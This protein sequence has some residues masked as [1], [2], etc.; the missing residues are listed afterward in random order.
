MK[1]QKREPNHFSWH[2]FNHALTTLEKQAGTAYKQLKHSLPKMNAK[3]VFN[4]ALKKKNQVAKEV[5]YYTDGIVETLANAD[6]LS[7]KNR[8]VKEA[9]QNVSNILHKLQKSDVALKAKDLAATKGTRLL[10]LLNFPTKRD[11]AKL[12]SRLSQLE[13]KLKT[14]PRTRAH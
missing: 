4:L 5:K 14:L 13:K 12:S 6:F 8:L 9:K 10:S 7:N 1:K 3:E 11:V 2:S